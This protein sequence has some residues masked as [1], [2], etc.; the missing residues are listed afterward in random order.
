MP[1]VLTF[2]DGVG[3]FPRSYINGFYTD[4]D[5]PI[6]G[7]ATGLLQ[8]T[9]IGFD[10][11]VNL[12]IRSAFYPP[13]SNVYSLDYVFDASAS[14]AYYL[15]VPYSAAFDIKLIGDPVDFSWR[16]KVIGSGTAGT[17]S[18]ASLLPMGVDYWLPR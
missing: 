17:P 18:R 4:D 13:S 16:I 10:V 3:N 14:Q 1:V 12:V 7:I 8:L 11:L 9:Q 5:Y 2:S 6:I 15:G